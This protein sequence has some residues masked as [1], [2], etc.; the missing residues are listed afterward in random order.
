M[1]LFNRNNFLSSPEG[2]LAQYRSRLK[3]RIDFSIEDIEPNAKNSM[4]VR[5]KDE[6]QRQLLDY[7]VRL[8][9]RA[10]R[11]PL[12]LRLVLSTTSKTPTH[13]HNVTKNLLDL[14]AVPRPNLLTG[15]SRLLYKDD[16]QI[17]ALSVSCQHGQTAPLILGMAMPLRSLLKDLEIAS[18]RSKRVDDERDWEELDEEDTVLEEFKRLLRSEAELRQLYGNRPYKS[19]V[20]YARQRTQEIYLRRTRFTLQELSEIYGVA[21]PGIGPDRTTFWEKMVAA[22]PMRVSFSEL[23]RTT[24]DSSAWRNEIEAKLEAFQSRFGWLLDPLLVP[25]ALEVV[26][27]PSPPSRNLGLHDLDNVLRTHLIPRVFEIL[28]PVSHSSFT[29]DIDAMKTALP[30]LFE[31]SAL[32]DWPDGLPPPPPESTR[33]GVTRYEVWRLPPAKE[34]SIGFVTITLVRDWS[35]RGDVFGQIDDEFDAWQESLRR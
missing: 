17:H 11:G 16:S 23:P 3:R 6:V 12:A 22:W 25:V 18:T 27:K 8:H 30:H 32:A 33:T 1:N 20:R 28:K 34:G 21:H 24:G 35:G 5:D 31:R 26:V 2:L 29:A 14:F 9:R 19:L 10:F 15:R 7:M 13:S 4:P